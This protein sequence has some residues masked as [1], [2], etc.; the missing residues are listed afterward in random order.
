MSIA[1]REPASTGVPSSSAKRS[2]WFWVSFAAIRSAS[3]NGPDGSSARYGG[4]D[5]SGAVV[6]GAAVVV[7]VG[8]AVVVGGAVVVVVGAAVVVV[9]P[10]GSS[11]TAG[12]STATAGAS[13]SSPA[14]PPSPPQPD[15]TRTAA[16]ATAPRSRT[17]E[18]D[19][20]IDGRLR[21]G[22]RSCACGFS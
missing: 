20:C 16:A 11:T 10:S 8:A 4:L 9:V 14:S 12:S 21:T 3:R 2:G 15:A 5:G 13:G 22:S 1:G 7:V 18:R 19:G 6:V 17:G